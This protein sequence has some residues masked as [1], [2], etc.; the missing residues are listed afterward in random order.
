MGAQTQKDRSTDD[1]ERFLFNLRFESRGI[2]QELVT[3][4]DTI[5]IESN[6]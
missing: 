2:V 3:D 5:N 6:R 1:V 4:I